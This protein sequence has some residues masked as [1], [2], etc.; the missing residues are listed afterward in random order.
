MSPRLA[1]FLVFLSGCPACPPV[2]VDRVAQ[3]K[4][5]YDQC[6]DLSE[7]MADYVQCRRAVDERCLP[8]KP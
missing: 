3:C 4:V 1:V 5:L 8:E 7:T 6:V 2:S